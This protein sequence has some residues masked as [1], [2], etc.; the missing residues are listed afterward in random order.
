MFANCAKPFDYFWRSKW[1]GNVVQNESW[2]NFV[3]VCTETPAVRQFAVFYW[4][5]T[6]CW[7]CR[8]AERSDGNSRTRQKHLVQLIMFLNCHFSPDTSRLVLFQNKKGCYVL[9]GDCAN[10]DAVTRVIIVG[11]SSRIAKSVT[12]TSLHWIVRRKQFDPLKMTAKRA[13]VSASSHRWHSLQSR[14]IFVSKRKKR[15]KSVGMS[16]WRCG[17]FSKKRRYS[18]Q[19]YAFRAGAIHVILAEV[20]LLRIAFLSFLTSAHTWGVRET[21]VRNISWHRIWGS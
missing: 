19:K 1:D 21:I 2:A 6:L 12:L 10:M 8:N 20:S 4:K 18:L 11:N 3:V 14:D 17:R 9:R 7:S 16:A 5:I 15:K 13:A